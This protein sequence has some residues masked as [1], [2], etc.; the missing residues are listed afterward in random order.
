MWAR[1][2]QL[3]LTLCNPW[4]A[5][6]QASLSMGFSW[7]EYWSGLPFPSPGYLPDPRTEPRSPMLQADSLVSEPPGKPSG[8]EPICQ[9]RRCKRCGID[10]WVRKIPWRR[11]Q[12]TPVFLPGKFHGR[13][14]WWATVHGVTKSHLHLYSCP[15]NRFISTIF[16]DSIYMC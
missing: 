15:A 16:L 2:L 13:G 10:P 11:W 1:A 7:Q 12:P 14:A 5:A 3:C 9:C 6:H 4:T 8:K